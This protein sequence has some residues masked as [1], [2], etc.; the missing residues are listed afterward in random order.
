MRTDW[1]AYL[2]GEE[3]GVGASGQRRDFDRGEALEEFGRVSAV[4]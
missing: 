1:G 3:G 4:D 2:R